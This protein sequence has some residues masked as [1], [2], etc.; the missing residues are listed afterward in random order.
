MGSMAVFQVGGAE[1]PLTIHDANGQRW[2]TAAQVGEALGHSNI[3]KL[4]SDLTNAGEIQEGK[5]FCNLTLH[6]D[7]DGRFAPTILLSCRGV[8]RVSMRAQT[9][10]AVAFRDFSEEVLYQVM[11]TGT[12]AGPSLKQF[13]TSR[14]YKEAAEIT[15][16]HVSLAKAMGTNLEMARALGVDRARMETGVDYGPLLIGCNAVPEKPLTATELGKMATPPVSAR[17]MNQML[18]AAGLQVK[19]DSDEW[20]P[21]E[22]GK[23]FCSLEPFKIRNSEHTGYRILWFK[24]VLDETKTSQEQASS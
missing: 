1:F 8:I 24:R 17:A 7:S 4:I 19:N 2:V 3:R 21:T 16:I 6:H 5:H 9:D 14:Q 12:Y 22:K 15:K 10:R 23:A 18:M 13:L 20:G 11:E